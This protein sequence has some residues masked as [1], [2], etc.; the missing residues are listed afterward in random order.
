MQC[1]MNCGNRFLET[2][3]LNSTGIHVDGRTWIWAELVVMGRA[4]KDDPLE[5]SGMLNPKEQG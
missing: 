4:D 5:R 1:R 3:R 2:E